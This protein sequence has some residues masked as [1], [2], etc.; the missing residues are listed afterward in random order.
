MA[1]EQFHLL[2]RGKITV[3]RDALVVI[4]RDE[5]VK[6]LFQI[7]ARAADAMHFVLTDHFSKGQAKFGGAHGPSQRDEHFAPA[8]E[9]PN[10]GLRGINN[11]G[12][13]EMAIMPLHK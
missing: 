11:H 13:I 7:R 1:V 3:M 8:I 12:C 10:V 4:V 2:L 6:I 5:I 9:M